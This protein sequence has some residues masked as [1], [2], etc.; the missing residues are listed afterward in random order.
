MYVVLVNVYLLLCAAVCV[1]MCMYFC[2]VFVR[3]YDNL[4][5]SFK[6]EYKITAQ[7]LFNL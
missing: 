1:H 5:Q 3:R 7:G 4:A 6:D 2:C